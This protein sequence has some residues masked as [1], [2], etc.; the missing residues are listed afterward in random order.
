MSFKDKATEELILKIL[1]LEVSRNS[2]ELIWNAEVKPGQFVAEV[3]TMRHRE[4]DRFRFGFVQR[5]AK[6]IVVNDDQFLET[7]EEIS[8]Y[9]A[10]QTDDDLKVNASQKQNVVWIET[11]YGEVYGWYNAVFKVLNNE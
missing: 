8:E 7:D 6:Q 11:I 1:T 5:V 3:S 9:N 2:D 4:R 10:A